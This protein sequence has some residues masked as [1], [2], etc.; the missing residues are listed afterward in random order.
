M[1]AY[2]WSQI[3]PMT[4][5]RIDPHLSRRLVVQGGASALALAALA[6]PARA[7][8]AAWE[9]FAPA[10]A[11]IGSA[12]PVAGLTLELPL[13]SEDGASVPL[14]A[15]A[16]QPAGDAVQSLHLFA[17]RNP[18]PEIA[19]FEFAPEARADVM[20]RVRLNES[21]TVI[22]VARTRTGMVLA[23][24]RDVRITASGCMTRADTAEIASEMEPR[25]R[26][27]GRARAG[28]PVEVLTLINHP[29]ETG[30]REGADGTILPQRIIRT[31]EATLNGAPLL[32]ATLHRSLAANP[33]LRFRMALPPGTAELAFEWT[34]D[35]GRVAKAAARVAVA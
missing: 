12:T 30:L 34:E 23:A 26:V 17:T 11:L 24:A 32:K 27:P 33:Y 10:R 35:T 21:Q 25:V 28:E 3:D 16:E 15:R 20:T 18:S 13:I 29:M 1:R 9:R 6:G 22:A 31:F 19:A 7:E 4:R 5:D 2:G 14:A 8:Q